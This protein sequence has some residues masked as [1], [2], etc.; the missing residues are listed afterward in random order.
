MMTSYL[1]SVFI[2]PTVHLSLIFILVSS[3][4][5][6]TKDEY[7]KDFAE[8]VVDVEA[9]AKNYTEEDWKLK[10]IDFLNYANELYNRFKGEFTE[11]DQKQIGRLKTKYLF[12]KS[13]FEMINLG[14][15]IKDGINQIKGAIDVIFNDKKVELNKSNVSI[16]K[17]VEFIVKQS[18]IFLHIFKNYF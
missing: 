15:Q 3:C 16:L 10:E 14:E 2:N 17:K 12:A 6:F 4:S 5:F 18:F 7:L 1:K 9:N 11:E 13:K 8:I